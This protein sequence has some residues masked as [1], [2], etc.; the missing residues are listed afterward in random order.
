MQLSTGWKVFWGVSLVK[1]AFFA[2]MLFRA[3][4]ATQQH[5]P[6]VASFVV[7]FL[8]TMEVIWWVVT[9]LVVLS[10]KGSQRKAAAVAQ[11]QAAQIAQA[12]AWETAELTPV[13]AGTLVL[14]PGETC[15][16]E[17]QASLYGPVTQTG[18]K[19]GY[20]GLSVPI[21]HTGIRARAGQFA[22]VNVSTTR[23]ALINQGPVYLTNK[24]IVILG[25]M[26]MSQLPLT[27]I[28][29]LEPH[30]DGVKVG[31]ANGK[32]M[33]IQTGTAQLGIYLHRLFT[34]TATTP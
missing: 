18:R 26:Q 17:G 30:L 7:G 28:L 2:F 16:L 5:Y 21:G 3:W 8:I 6:D 33:T 4:Q 1:Y 25:A 12:K 31:I 14:Q 22:S 19:G 24:R 13:S 23:M 32:P 15:Y 11:A 27:D 10:R 20:G 34:P 29:T 9:G